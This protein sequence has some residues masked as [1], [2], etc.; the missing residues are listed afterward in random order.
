LKLG[1]ITPVEAS[2]QLARPIQLLASSPGQELEDPKE[3]YVRLWCLKEIH[4][5]RW[6]FPFGD[7]P[8]YLSFG[9][10]QR[11]ELLSKEL[12][13]ADVQ[14]WSSIAELHLRK[15]FTA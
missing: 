10:K 9:E 11:F 14:C 1:P 5:E 4:D 6:F 13:P 8:H 12:P 3:E 7:I 2:E 15:R